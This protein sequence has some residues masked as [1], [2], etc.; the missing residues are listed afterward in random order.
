M[1]LSYDPLF[2]CKGASMGKYDTAM[3][4]NLGIV[5]HNHAGKTSLVE[6]MLFDTGMTKKLGKVTDGSSSMDFEEEEI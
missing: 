4:R 3:L 2:C 5:A 1:E 6:A